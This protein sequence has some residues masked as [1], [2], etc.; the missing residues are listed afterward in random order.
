MESTNQSIKKAKKPNQKME[1]TTNSNA[2]TNT[3]I[4]NDNLISASSPRYT[5]FPKPLKSPNVTTNSN[6]CADSTSCT[7]STFSI[8]STL[9]LVSNLSIN[10]PAGIS[11]KSSTTKAT[12]QTSKSLDNSTHFST[13]TTSNPSNKSEITKPKNIIQSDKLLPAKGMTDWYSNKAILRQKIKRTLQEVFEEF[14]FVPLETPE[15]E[16][17]DVLTFKG[18]EEIQKEIY[19][20]I[21]QGERDLGLRFDHTVPL[22]R[23]VGANKDIRYPFRR[24]SIGTVFRNG[25]T[26]PKQGRYRAFTQCDVDIIGVSEV[27][28][29]IELIT[30]AKRAF[31][32]LKLGDI[33]IS[34]NNRKILNGILDSLDIKS[35]ETINL[36]LI[37]LDKLDKIGFSKV[38]E[39]LNSLSKNKQISAIALQKLLLVL[40]LGQD[41]TL[42]NLELLNQIS[43][44]FPDN[45]MIIK[46]LDEIKNILEFF[47]EGGKDSDELLRFEPSLARGL[48]YYTGTIMEI[49]LKDKSTIKSAILGGG[50]YDNMIGTFRGTGEIIPAVGF[51]FGLERITTILESMGF[52][53]NSS[54]S[55]I[56]LFPENAELDIGFKLANQ[57]RDLGFKV[58]FEL[59][60]KK[61]SKTLDYAQNSSIPFVLVYKYSNDA[62]DSKIEFILRDISQRDQLKIKEDEL[63]KILKQK[64]ANPNKA[65]Y[66]KD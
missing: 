64:L 17:L 43:K 47:K 19:K 34:I 35:N 48:D 41:K 38:K 26:Q 8:S 66:N 44:E 56:I 61:L 14:G 37:S 9:S 28:A 62:Q 49:F 4:I 18:G 50:R 5:K 10:P 24:Y 59:K 12:A 6:P 63:I 30:L 51:S 31:A 36:I 32:K 27:I 52:A 33:E 23:F 29:E 1:N 13:S 54:N 15:I 60:P 3:K 45:K 22:A 40:K 57:L 58:E 55:Q 65:D 7:D 42:S 11:S 16:N 2:N 21:D 39:E 25:P 53:K 46:G 20:V